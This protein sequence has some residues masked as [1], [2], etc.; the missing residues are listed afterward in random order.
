VK[1]AVQNHEGG[2]LKHGQT[3]LASVKALLSGVAL[4]GLAAASCQAQATAVPLVSDACPNVSVGQSISLDWNPV[5]DPSWPV[6]GLR[7][8]D[9]TF[10]PVAEDGVG[11]RRMGL[12][13]G[14]H[15]TAANISPLGNGF[16]HIEVKLTGSRIPLGKYRLVSA[17]A[18]PELDSDFKGQLPEMT[19]SPVEERYCITVIRSQSSSQ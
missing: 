15:H 18:A 14:A 11:L 3:I 19:R 9:L 12:R 5:F 13:L 2:A 7:G 4:L 6:T 17:H 1:L 8:F 16:F 10:S